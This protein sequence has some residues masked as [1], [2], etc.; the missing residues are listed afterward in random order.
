M[1]IR[2]SIIMDLPIIL[3]TK[4]MVSGVKE[5]NQEIYVCLK[6]IYGTIL[7]DTEMGNNLS[8]FTNSNAMTE[9]S[10]EVTLSKIANI[11]VNSIK[12]DRENIAIDYVYQGIK[13]YYIVPKED[14]ISG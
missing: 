1:F 9:E 12:V 3:E 6:Q 8:I 5:K 10:V 11:K 13:E 7:H 2:N 4:K 14:V